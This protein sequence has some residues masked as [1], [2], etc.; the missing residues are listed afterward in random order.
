M[1]YVSIKR[2][3]DLNLKTLYLPQYLDVS[4]KVLG[5]WRDHFNSIIPSLEGTTS[6]LN[7]HYTTRED[8]VQ[9][10]A[11]AALGRGKAIKLVIIRGR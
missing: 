11:R 8:A 7:G 2:V 6:I 1:K 10:C 4:L 3:I 5:C 9:K